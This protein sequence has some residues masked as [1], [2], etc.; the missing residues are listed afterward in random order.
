MAWGVGYAAVGGASV[1]VPLYAIALDAS[2]AFVGLI[3]ATA[4]L[5]GVPGAL[6]WGR[7]AARTKRRRPFVL[8]TLAAT[9]GTLALVPLASSPAAVL[10]LNALL[11]FA[12]SA[13]VP[14]LNLIVVEGA[15]VDEWDGR[16]ASLNAWQGYG[17]VG[18]LV[19][20]TVWTG[21]AP[22][23]GVDGVAGQRLLFFVL[24]AV[25]ATALVLA[26]AWYPEPASVDPDRYR[27]VS[28]RF[29]RTDWGAG[30]VLRGS[31]YGPSRIYWALTA[32]G[33]RGGTGSLRSLLV[34]V[35]TRL[36]R[37]L[38]A[39]AVFS[40]GFAVFWGPVPAYLKADLAEGAVFAVYLAGNLGSAAC[41]TPVGRLAGRVPHRTLQAAALAVRCVLFPGVAL[42]TAAAAGAL[43]PVYAVGFGLIGVTW[44][45]I[46]VTTTGIVTRLSD[47]ASRGRALGLQAAAAGAATAVGSAVGG[48][49]AGAAGYLV[50]FAV[51]AA[52]VLAGIALL[53]ASR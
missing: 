1:L 34:G 45:V 26:R 11:W 28:R 49:V 41:Y 22:R 7:L 32:A 31:L 53:L 9:A 14:V 19:V 6:L 38:L 37:Y 36:R 12:V 23:F 13:A 20:G 47:E 50:A 30:R 46:A 17:W 25:A 44:A 35:P 51:A 40:F 16:I 4:A 39:V 42:V 15:P 3:A 21:V 43:L 5:V 27:R 2:L 10:L 52:A 24:A 48:V 18:G 8:V 29:S 33:G